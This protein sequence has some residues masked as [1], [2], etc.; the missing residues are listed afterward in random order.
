MISLKTWFAGGRCMIYPSWETH[1]VFGREEHV[2]EAR[3][4][5]MDKYYFNKLLIAHTLFE[6][7]EAMVLD[8]HLLKG[9]N[10]NLARHLI[11]KNGDAIKLEKE[12]NDKIKVNDY[13]LFVD[14]FGYENDIFKK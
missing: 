5:Q 4:T 2:K 3:G 14:K 10:V 9:R 8:N 12:W 7:E 1:H 6:P 11:K 13:S